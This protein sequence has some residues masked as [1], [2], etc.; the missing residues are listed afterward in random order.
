MFVLTLKKAACVQSVAA[1]QSFSAEAGPAHCLYQIAWQAA[2][3]GR[4]YQ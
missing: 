3:D 1:E 2:L 4:Q